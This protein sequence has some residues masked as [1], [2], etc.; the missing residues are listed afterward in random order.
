MHQHGNEIAP[1][2]RHR[3]FIQLIESIVFIHSKGVI[4][5]DLRPENFLVHGTLPVSLDL[6]LCDFGGSTGEELQL[7]GGK[8]PN[9]GFYNPND[10]WE[11][12]YAVNIFAL[13]SVLYTIITGR[14][15]FRATTGQFTS[16]EE[17]EESDAYVDGRFADGIFPEVEGLFGGEIIRGCWTN[18]LSR[19]ADIMASTSLLQIKY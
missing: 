2:L 7:F 10:A 11:A 1:S 13:G 4:H 16:V 14:W 5:S 18:K 6:C 15:P 8:R 19:A 17:M 3:W 12:T 9:S